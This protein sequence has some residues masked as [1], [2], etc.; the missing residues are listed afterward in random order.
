MNIV[1]LLRVKY[2]FEVRL[3]KIN[4][5]FPDNEE[6]SI[7]ALINLIAIK[8]IWSAKL[9]NREPAFR[10]FENTIKMHYKMEQYISRTNDTVTQ[11]QAKWNGL[12]SLRDT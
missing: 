11:W 10:H 6:R 12:H 9:D 2:N 1:T 7:I 3:E 8:C 4:N 5:I